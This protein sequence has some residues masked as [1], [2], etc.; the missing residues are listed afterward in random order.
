MP[1]RVTHFYELDVYVAGCAL[2]LAIHE[3]SKRWPKEEMFALTDQIRRASRAVG[4]NIAEAWAK[5]PYPAH[6][7][8]KLTDADA[9]LQET[10]HWILRANAYGYIGAAA[11]DSF[12]VQADQVGRQLGR[13]RSTA[14]SFR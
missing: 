3:A 1:N 5:R 10:K 13:M 9:E 7:A 4:A 12:W 6:F 11:F 8:S 2:D 14:S